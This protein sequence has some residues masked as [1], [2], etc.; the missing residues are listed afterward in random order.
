MSPSN[1]SNKRKISDYFVKNNEPEDKRQRASSP[2]PPTTTNPDEVDVNALRCPKRPIFEGEEGRSQTVLDCGQKYIG[3]IA[4]EECGMIYCVDSAEDLREHAKFHTHWLN[5]FQI[6]DHFMKTFMQFH[7][8]HHNDFKVFFL[9]TFVE[10]PF[11]RCISEHMKKINEQLGYKCERNSIWAFEKRIFFI[12]L[13]RENKMYIGGICIVEKVFRAWTDVTR[14][15]VNNGQDLNDW[16][17]GVDRIWVDPT[18]RRTK[19]AYSLLDAATT[20]DRQMEFRSRR[21]RIAFSDPTDDGKILAKR[22]IET[23][24]KPEDQFGGEIL[25]Y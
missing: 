8:R 17:V 20:Q 6:P 22:F 1:N 10:E 13:V 25:V 4:C 3:N 7:S 11:K 18:V 9:G 5:R 15:E 21:L 24:Y 2:P 19:I 16:I 14:R 23:R 12:L